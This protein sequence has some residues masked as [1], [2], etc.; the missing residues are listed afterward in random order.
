M[1]GE[2]RSAKWGPAGLRC[3]SRLFRGHSPECS[4]NIRQSLF[5]ILRFV[6]EIPHHA[7]PACKLC[8]ATGARQ[9]GLG[10]DLSGRAQPTGPHTQFEL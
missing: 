7:K 9:L 8:S 5:D 1:A 6:R 2:F 10:K 4:F 3:S